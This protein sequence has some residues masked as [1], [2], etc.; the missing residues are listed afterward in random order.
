MQ[1]ALG[2]WGTFSIVACDPEHEFWG[3]AVATKPIGV[4]SVVP[5][6]EWRA[7]ALATQANTNYWYGPKGLEELRRGRSAA[8]V[9]RRLIRADPARERR[10][11]GVVDGRGNAAAWTGSECS[12]WAGHLVGEGYTCQGNLL[13][14]AEVVPAM[15]RTFERSRGG[16]GRRLYAALVAGARAG[17]DRRGAESSA[18][19]VAHRE[20][21]FDAAWPDRWIDLRVDQ[22]ANPIAELGRLYRLD[23]KAT[24]RLLAARARRFRLRRTNRRRSTA[25]PAKRPRGPPP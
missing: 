11:L 20:R 3:V 2:R 19:L 5:W 10:Q 17:G 24:G 12:D 7:G 23:E 16:L 6:A 14:N 9:V 8:E 21:W 15:A 22:N 25:A 13:R 4:G 1:A 18:L